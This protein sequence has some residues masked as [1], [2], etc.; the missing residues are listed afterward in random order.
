VFILTKL[1]SLISKQVFQYSVFLGLSAV[2]F[3]LTGITY[4]SNKIS[5]QRFFGRINPFLAV[6]IVFLIGMIL[7]TYLLSDGQFAAYQPGN[8][9]GLLL[10][11]LLA[12]PFGIV[13][14]LVDR[15]SPFPIDTN[16][17]Y[18]DSL[19]FYPVMGY[20]AEI[21][22]LLLP[23]CLAYFGLGLL[24]GKA[25]S[26]RIIWISIL[27]AALF[28]PIFQI[29]FMVGRDP[30]WKVAYVGLHIYLLSL[31]QLLLFKR[32]DFITMYTFRLSYYF[33]WHILWGHLRL[34]IL[35]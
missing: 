25:N 24:L 20:V 4:V 34:S 11:A 23:F 28:E 7:F 18:P 16:I 2:V 12:L 22:F 21:L 27:F 30:I 19:S 32:Y 1:W 6:F 31:V 13:I 3:V 17:P 8:Y 15:A 5:F 29:S 14:I 26:T 9:K 33:L 35:F 10:A